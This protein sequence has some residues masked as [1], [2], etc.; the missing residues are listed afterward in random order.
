VRRH[1]SS[2][3]ALRLAACRTS[4][5]RGHAPVHANAFASWARVLGVCAAVASAG[6]GDSGAPFDRSCAGEA[7]PNC[8]PFEY[9][10]AS[11]GSLTPAAIET[12]DPT[13]DATFHVRLETCGTSSP[14]PHEVVVK[15]LATRGGLDGGDSLMVFT[16]ATLRDD[17]TSGDAVAGDGVIDQTFPS[18]LDSAIPPNADVTLSFEPRAALCVGDAV[19]VPYHTGAHFS[20]DGGI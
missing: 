2:H 20:P 5:P 11:D 9:S 1:A 4:G 3:A 18:P 15:L 13:A 16:I 7:V 8:R 19:E 14:T 17:G 10:R 6:C 12:G